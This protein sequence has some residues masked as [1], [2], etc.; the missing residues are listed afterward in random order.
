MVGTAET[1]AGLAALIL[2]V[3]RRASAQGI[4]SITHQT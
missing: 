1:K 3:L 4:T 2:W